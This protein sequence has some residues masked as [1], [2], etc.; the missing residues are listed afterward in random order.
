MTAKCPSRLD[1]SFSDWLCLDTCQATT[2]VTKSSAKPPSKASAAASKASKSKKELG[3]KDVAV[4]SEA[5]AVQPIEA[6]ISEE[7]QQ[8]RIQE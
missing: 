5:E 3:V 4:V 7:E 2:S 8:R 6:D 1:A